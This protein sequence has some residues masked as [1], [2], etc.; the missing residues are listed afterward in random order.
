MLSFFRKTKTATIVDIHSHL[1]P[2]LDDG[3]TDMDNAIE[4]ING[5]YLLGYK[6]L[7]TTPHISDI[8]KNSKESIL[9]NY[10]L[11]KEELIKRDID[12]EI[13]LGAEY[14]IDNHFIELLENQ[15]LLAFGDKNYLLFEFSYFTAPRDIEELIYDMTLKGYTPILAHPERYIYWHNSFYKYV[16]LKKMGV[17]FQLNLNSLSGYYGKEIKECAEK[18][19]KKS[20][21]DFV[22]T[23]THHIKHIESLK[24]TLSLS[25]YRKIF[26]YNNILNDII[27]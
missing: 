15:K 3:A 12:I 9:S 24:K 7:I 25:I 22:G 16:E 18:L 19:I 21:I 26:K 4:L 8:F 2:S 1:I 13:E 23:D 27:N 5:L 17:F 6:K 20:Y 11:L 14:Y 10:S